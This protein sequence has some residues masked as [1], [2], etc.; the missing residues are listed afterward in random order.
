[1]L[2]RIKAV[3]VAKGFGFVASEDGVD[4]FFHRSFL[5]GGLELSE[6]LVGLLV[7]FE[8][9]KHALKGPRAINITPWLG[10]TPSPEIL[11]H[12]VLAPVTVA[13]I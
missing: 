4:R 13:V 12:L 7:A 5:L 9:S 6:T 10:E 11:A 1:M 3:T 2:G 8:T